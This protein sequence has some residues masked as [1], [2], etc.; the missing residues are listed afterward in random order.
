VIDEYRRFAFPSTEADV[1]RRA[2]VEAAAAAVVAAGTL[3]CADAAV[4]FRVKLA[5][6]PVS[7]SAWAPSECTAASDLTLMSTHEG[8][9]RQAS[10]ANKRNT[11]GTTIE[12]TTLRKT[13]E[14]E[15]G[16]PFYWYSIASRSISGRRV[17]AGDIRSTPPVVPVS[18]TAKSRRNPEDHYASIALAIDSTWT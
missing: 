10:Q 8:T 7:V 18:D 5:A 2:G 15:S 6:V 1:V 9:E 3:S 16:M 14:A 11:T 13:G 17:Q 12:S 4:G